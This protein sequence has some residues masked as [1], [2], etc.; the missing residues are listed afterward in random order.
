[1]RKTVFF[2]LD[3]MLTYVPVIVMALLAAATWWLVEIT[4]TAPEVVEAVEARQEPD[5]IVDEFMAERFDASGALR[6][7]MTGDQVRRYPAANRIAVDQ[8]NM[9]T[10]EIGTD[11]QQA[12]PVLG[13]PGLEFYRTTAIAD[14]GFLL[15]NNEIIELRDNAYVTRQPLNAQG[16]AEKVE[17]RGDELRILVSEDR[18]V[19]N[20]PVDI[21]QDGTRFI[22]DRMIYHNAANT[23]EMLGDVR[24]VVVNRP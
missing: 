9:M 8:V 15:N 22:A 3:W 12:Q 18:M 5:Y 2:V 17:F 24:G 21:T 7:W 1:M 16:D 6:S 14:K 23:L 13:T 20:K 10:T 11:E 4:P 19:S